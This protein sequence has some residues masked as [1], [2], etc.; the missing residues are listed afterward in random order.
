MFEL[1]IIFRTRERAHIKEYQMLYTIFSGYFFFF[2]FNWRKIMLT[3]GDD[4][5]ADG[6]DDDEGSLD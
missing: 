5:D 2:Y 1:V 3:M 4:D 6:D